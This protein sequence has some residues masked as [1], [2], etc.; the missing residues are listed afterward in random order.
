MA[1]PFYSIVIVETTVNGVTTAETK[2]YKSALEANRA[3]MSG[4]NA[5]KRVFLYEKPNPTKHTTNSTQPYPA[6]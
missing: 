5:G 1:Y 2:I 4:L 6:T 3:Y